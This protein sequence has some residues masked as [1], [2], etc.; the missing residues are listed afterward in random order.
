V[1]GGLTSLGWCQ[2]EYVCY[3]ATARMLAPTLV[4]CVLTR[5]DK[6]EDIASHPGG[7]N[8]SGQAVPLCV[9]ASVCGWFL[10][11]QQISRRRDVAQQL[12][13]VHSSW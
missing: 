2:Q 4:Q 11:V 6:P 8:P 12:H 7:C 5:V 13:S 1:W 10:H 9:V 3:E